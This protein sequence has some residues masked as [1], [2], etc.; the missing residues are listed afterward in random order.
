[1][2]TEENKEYLKYT[3]Y[4]PPFVSSI[5]EGGTAER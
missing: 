5:I 3:Y 1:M 2:K 4:S